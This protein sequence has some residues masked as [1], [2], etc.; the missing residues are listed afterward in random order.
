MYNIAPIVVWWIENIETIHLQLK[1]VLKF[2]ELKSDSVPNNSNRKRLNYKGT[3]V[4]KLSN[5]SLISCSGWDNAN[6]SET[7]INKKN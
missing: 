4:H 7:E 3:S 1:L 6:K 2:E 5:T